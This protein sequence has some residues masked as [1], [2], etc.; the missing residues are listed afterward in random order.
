MTG[1]KRDRQLGGS[2]PQ[3]TSCWCENTVKRRRKKHTLLSAGGRRRSI[4]S[5]APS[6]IA[7]TVAGSVG[8]FSRGT[9]QTQEAR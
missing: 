9:N 8:I 2:A 6:L 5:Y 3:H 7:A 4:F 1:R